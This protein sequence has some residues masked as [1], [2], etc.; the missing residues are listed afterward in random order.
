MKRLYDYV[1]A[2]KDEYIALLQKFCRQPSIS[3][4]NVGI[5]EMVDLIVKE[6]ATIQITPEIVET[7]G[8]PIIY[9]EI[10]GKTRT[11]RFLSTTIMTYSPGSVG[12][13]EQRSFWCGNSRRKALFPGRHRQ[14]GKP[15]GPG[16]RHQSLSGRLWSDSFKY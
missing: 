13:M 4:Q 8:N 5:K 7:S 10:K 15:A 1:D 11:A 14:Q 6:L 16:M 2:H 3:A 9:G 12:R